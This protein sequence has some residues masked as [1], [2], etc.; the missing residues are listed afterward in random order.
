MKVSK[1][2][3]LYGSLFIL[4]LYVNILSR[5]AS[6]FGYL[7]EIIA[8]VSFL[9]VLTHIRKIDTE[10]FVVLAILAVMTIIALAGNMCF[11]YQTYTEAIFKD[12]LAF[13]KLPITFIA[14]YTWSKDKNFNEAHNVAVRISKISTV[15][16]FVGCIINIFVDVGLSHDIRY[17]FRSYKFLFSHPTYLV[18]ALVIM[19]VVL[20]S[21]QEKRRKNTHILNF[22]I[23]F[24]ILFSFR[25]KGFGYI[26]LL[27]VIMIILPRRKKVK[28]HY[29]AIAGIIAFAVSY[30][31]LLEYKSW[32]WSPRSALYVNGLQLALRVF[33]IG[34]GFATFN[35][36]LSGEYY[37]RAYY[38]FGLEK[39][40][41]LSPIDYIDAGDAQLPYYYT[42]FGLI[43][44]ALFLV[45]LYLLVKKVKMLYC[46]KP[47]VMKSAYLLVGYLVIGALVEAVFTNETGVTSMVVLLV[48][49]NWNTRNEKKGKSNYI[50]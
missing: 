40:P 37:S 3:L 30:Q 28:L 44:F 46:E 26:A 6:F 25:D 33:P 4:I 10:S 42:Q 35:S 2:K 16:I 22:M 23:L 41:G 20:V 24:C 21:D 32:S 38:L 1:K 45:V 13:Y 27:F 50:E 43:G 47:M 18:Y 31:K 15:I 36:F 8:I 48:Y 49:I 19:S 5:Y 12:I 7:D 9:Y 17:G 29:F 11:Q 34:S 39:K 14:V